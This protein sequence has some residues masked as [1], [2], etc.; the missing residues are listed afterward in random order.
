MLILGSKQES[1]AAAAI[2]SF[3]WSQSKQERVLIGL[4]SQNR[5]NQKKEPEVMHISFE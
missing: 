1:R 2:V 5:L 3:V 4:D